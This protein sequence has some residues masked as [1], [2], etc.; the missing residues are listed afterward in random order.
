MSSDF[1]LE[2]FRTLCNTIDLIALPQ[3]EVSDTAY[4][5]PVRR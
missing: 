5:F 4:G 2:V 3:P 1:D